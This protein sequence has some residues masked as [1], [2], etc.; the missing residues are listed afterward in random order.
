MV[1]V[2][3]FLMACSKPDWSDTQGKGVFLKDTNGQW[4][5][6]NIWAQWCDPCR[7]EIPELNALASAGSIRVLGYD[8][9]NSQGEALVNKAKK[10]GI[11]FPVITESPLVLLEAKTPQVLPATMIVNPDG[12]LIEI[13][14]GPQ[15]LDSLKKKVQALKDKVGANG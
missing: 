13:L 11:E 1:W 15:T 2:T 6:I 5:V 8:F 4:T 14:Y 12:K 9:D 10:L 7:E 3:F